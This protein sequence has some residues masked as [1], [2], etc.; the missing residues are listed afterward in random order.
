MLA[1][2]TKHVLLLKRRSNDMTARS[3]PIAPY[4]KAYLDFAL[5]AGEDGGALTAWTGILDPRLISKLEKVEEVHA[6]GGG[7]LMT[8]LI[9]ECRGLAACVRELHRTR[10]KLMQAIQGEEIR[11]IT[12]LPAH[13]RPKK[14]R[15]KETVHANIRQYTFSQDSPGAT[16]GMD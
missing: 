13:R 11:A 9:K 12:K 4:F 6:V 15:R 10:Y 8:T 3:I 5:Q 14:G 16:L 1:C 7:V 2:W